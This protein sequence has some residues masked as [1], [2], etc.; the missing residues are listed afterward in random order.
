[1]PHVR[2]L[3]ETVGKDRPKDVVTTKPEIC[4]R[5]GESEYRYMLGAP[6][7]EA[8]V[9]AESGDDA[10]ADGSPPVVDLFWRIYNSE[11]A[12][13]AAS[14]R[15]ELIRADAEV[16][17]PA[18]CA[19]IKDPVVRAAARKAGGA[20]TLWVPYLTNKNELF[21]GDELWV[22]KQQVE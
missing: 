8:A 22:K 4:V 2:E 18:G 20:I 19:T 11:K 13:A 5:V 1:M 3:G 21:S 6:A 14:P 15:G 12:K 17:V 9:D 16:T 10:G 7:C